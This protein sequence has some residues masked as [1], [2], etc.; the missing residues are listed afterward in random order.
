MIAFTRQGLAYALSFMQSSS[1]GAG[2]LSMD[3]Y[4]GF[5]CPLANSVEGRHALLYVVH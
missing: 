4:V 5:P 1:V 2:L 3:E